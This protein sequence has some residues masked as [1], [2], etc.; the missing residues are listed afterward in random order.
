MKRWGPPPFVFNAFVRSYWNGREKKNTIKQ[1][2]KVKIEKEEEI[3]GVIH[4]LFNFLSGNVYD[5]LFSLLFILTTSFHIFI[6]AV[7]GLRIGELIKRRTSLFQPLSS[8]TYLLFTFHFALRLYIRLRSY[9]F[10]KYAK[11]L[12]EGI[13]RYIYKCVVDCR[14][15]ISIIP[16][17]RQKKHT[18]IKEN[19]E[20]N[21]HNLMLTIFFFGSPLFHFHLNFPHSR[22]GFSAFVCCQFC[23]CTF[24]QR[25]FRWTFFFVLLF[26]G[27]NSNLCPIRNTLNTHNDRVG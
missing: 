19:E 12:W 8:S 3:F 14:P 7:T 20:Q 5:A 6:P 21:I 17:K 15:L 25:I 10:Y 16:Q 24:Y 22:N 27:I 11:F 18:K 23:Y 2:K 9:Y 26:E 13:H 1:R 4:F